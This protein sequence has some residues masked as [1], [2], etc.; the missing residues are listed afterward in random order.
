[1]EEGTTGKRADFTT[2]LGNRIRKEGLDA[3]EITT[4]RPEPEGKS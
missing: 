2:S 3:D 4:D 1:M